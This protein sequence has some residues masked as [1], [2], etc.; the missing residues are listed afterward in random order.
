MRVRNNERGEWRMVENSKKSEWG[1]GEIR[2]KKSRI[3]IILRLYDN[4][5][6]KYGVS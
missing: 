5:L 6:G 1:T 3:I 2:G 4:L